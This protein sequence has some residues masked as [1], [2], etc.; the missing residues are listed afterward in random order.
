MKNWHKPLR[1]KTSCV[2]KFRYFCSRF[3]M[4]SAKNIIAIVPRRCSCAKISAR[5]VDFGQGDSRRP[6]HRLSVLL[7]IGTH[8]TLENPSWDR[9]VH[10]VQASHLP[11]T[12]GK[13][14]QTTCTPRRRPP[15]PLLL[16][17]NAS[18][19]EAGPRWESAA[20]MWAS[21]PRVA[22]SPRRERLCRAAPQTRSNRTQTVWS[23]DSLSN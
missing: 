17:R 22:A 13:R 5:R 12:S 11:H 15:L 3:L 10:K 18:T 23:D 7:I 19:H 8:G 1:A 6:H 20:M 16:G 14:R 21:S 2:R 9:S 4:K